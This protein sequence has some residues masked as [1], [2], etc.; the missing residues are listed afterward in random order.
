MKKVLLATTI[1]GMSA[2]FAAAEIGFT[3]SAS[4]GFASESGAN[5]EPYSKFELGVAA[6]GESD[7]GLTFGASGKIAG[8]AS[9][10][11]GGDFAASGADNMAV[12]PAAPTA[13]FFKPTIFIAGDFGKVT[14]KANGFK[15]SN[16][17][18]MARAL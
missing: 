6:T 7:S 9:P 8:G 18:T 14:V 3:G 11:R 17:P 13:G 12:A 16:D 4:A 5:F 2:G 15:N 10:D 1:L